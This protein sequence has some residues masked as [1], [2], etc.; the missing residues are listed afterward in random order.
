MKKGSKKRG[1]FS[2]FM[3]VFSVFRPQKWVKKCSK[4]VIFDDFWTTFRARSRRLVAQIGQNPI[5]R[6]MVE[7]STFSTIFEVRPPSLAGAQRSGQTRPA[8]D[9]EK[10]PPR[11]A[12]GADF[13]SLNDLQ[14]T[15][16]RRVGTRFRGRR[17]P[18]VD[19]WAP[20]GLS[21]VPY[22]SP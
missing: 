5:F 17:E 20:F 2:C 16:C 22:R 15:F 21:L 1:H 4:S 18:K 14:T 7:K 12:L 8:P 10:C 6:K 19:I 3:P 11:H 13:W 9:S